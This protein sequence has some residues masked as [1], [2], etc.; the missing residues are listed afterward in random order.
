M[1]EPVTASLPATSAPAAAA[2]SE[3]AAEGEGSRSSRSLECGKD[4][5][6]IL[7]QRALELSN[8]GDTSFRFPETEADIGLF[9]LAPPFSSLT[10]SS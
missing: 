2:A 4:A 3:T 10:D 7:D 1:A 8:F 6:G 5:R 9:L